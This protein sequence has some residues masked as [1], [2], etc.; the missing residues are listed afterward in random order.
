MRLKDG[1]FAVAWGEFAGKESFAGDDGR[2]YEH[3]K[4]TF[5]YAN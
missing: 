2:R 1:R 3:F 5:F 4:V